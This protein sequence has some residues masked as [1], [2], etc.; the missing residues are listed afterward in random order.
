[1]D[2]NN[3]S[4]SWGENCGFVLTT[5]S[6]KILPLENFQLYGIYMYMYVYIYVQ[7]VTHTFTYCI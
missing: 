3:Q 5:K 1:M 7:F 6:T 2:F 4:Y